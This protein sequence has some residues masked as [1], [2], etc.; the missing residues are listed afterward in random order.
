[1]VAQ[2]AMAMVAPW[3]RPLPLPPLP[4]LE[5]E[6]VEEAAAEGK[7]SVVLIT[8]AEEEMGKTVLC[9]D[10]VGTNRVGVADENSGLMP[11]PAVAEVNRTSSPTVVEVGAAYAVE[12][13]VDS[14][15]NSD[16]TCASPEV[17]QKR[18]PQYGEAA[19]VL[20]AE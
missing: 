10:E 4:L 6:I 18:T 2:T 12:P 8:G 17:S 20:F 16:W 1:M 11:P 5:F 9:P 7:M 13:G 3:E 15:P 14:Q 19:S